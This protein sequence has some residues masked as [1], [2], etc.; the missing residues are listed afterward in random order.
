M[1]ERLEKALEFSNFMV[2]L[3]NQKR[4]FQETYYQDILHYHRGAQFS[5][6]QQLICFV[7]IMLMEEQESVVLIDDNGRPVE[8]EDLQKF[9]DTILSVYVEASN[10]YM[11]KYDH[12]I[13][14]RSIEKMV[15]L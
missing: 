5:V 9:Y 12:L 14:N 10:S 3:N 11:S 6:N 4:I 1:D 8:I 7:K 15:E 13:N 2:T